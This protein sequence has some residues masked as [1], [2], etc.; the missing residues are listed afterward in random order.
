MRTATGKI[1][2]FTFKEGVLSAAAHDLRFRLERFDVRL[3]GESVEGELDLTSL[4]LDGPV[5]DGTVRV[6]EYDTGKR[7]EVERAMHTE[8]LHTA[9]HPVARFSGR[10]LPRGDGFAVTG[11]L[12]LA[13]QSASLGF[14]VSSEE[15]RY[16]AR[17]ALR[18]SRWG[19]PQYKAMVGT[20]RL[21]D[22]VRVDLDLVEAH[23]R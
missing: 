13:G 3:D 19:L 16:R 2:V 12:E 7:A 5:R 15:G 20:I 10:A 4:K 17:I 1:Q 9:N 14:D 11:A 23:M 21:K 18:P 22:E 8:I 6:D